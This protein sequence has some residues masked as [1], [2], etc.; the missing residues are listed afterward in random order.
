MQIHRVGRG[1]KEEVANASN[2]W[3]KKRIGSREDFE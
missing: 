3:E 2:N 1:K